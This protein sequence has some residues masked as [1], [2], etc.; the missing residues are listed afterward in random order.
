M[1]NRR[2]R[3][4][5]VEATTYDSGPV[6]SKHGVETVTADQRLLIEGPTMTGKRDLMLSLLQ[7][8]LPEEHAMVITTNKSAAGIQS[9]I[10]TA[11][12]PSPNASIIDCSTI[13]S[14][15]DSVAGEIEIVG[16]PEDLTGLGIAVTKCSRRI[17]EASTNGVRVGIDSISSFLQY[18]DEARV[19]Y[20]LQVL[21]GRFSAADYLTVSTLSISSHPQQVVESV[22]SL[23]DGRI[24]LRESDAGAIEARVLGLEGADRTWRTLD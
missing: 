9:S 11:D 10:A 22:R 3:S 2:Q 15:P 19:L 13:D 14:T 7:T 21:L 12:T 20:C 17:E 23:H 5:R 6:L 16:S 4:Q 8:G 24:E 18:I 1:T